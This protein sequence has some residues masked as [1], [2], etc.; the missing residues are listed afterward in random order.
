LTGKCALML[1]LQLNYFN[2]SSLVK[3]LV[4]G[5]HEINAGDYPAFLYVLNGENYDSEKIVDGLL[6]GSFF[7]LAPSKSF[8]QIGHLC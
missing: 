6:R 8:I 7:F 4:E 3:D 1:I 2:L 5:K